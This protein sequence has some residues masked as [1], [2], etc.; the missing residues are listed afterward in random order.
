MFDTCL[1]HPRTIQKWYH[2]IDVRPM[3]TEPA[4]AALQLRATADKGK[5]ILCSLVMDEMAIRK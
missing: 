5:P 1:P 4:F 3:F 2:S